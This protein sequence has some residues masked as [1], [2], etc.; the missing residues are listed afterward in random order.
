M[1]QA[2]YRKW[3]PRTFRDVCGQEHITS[4]L[5]YEAE[6]GAF[7]H[8]YLFCGSRGTGKTTCAKILAKVVNCEHP[9]D[10]NPCGVCSACQAID[11]GSATDV[12]EMDAASNNGVENIRDIRDEVIYSPSSLRYRVYIIDEVHMLSASAFNALLKTLE[13]PPQHVVFIL[14]TTELQ[15]LPATIVSRCQRFDFRRIST[16]TLV[17]RLEYIAREEEIDLS[18]DAARMIAKLAQGG[19]RDAISLLELC[20]GGGRTVDVAAVEEAVGISGRDAMIKTVS[21]V[22]EKDYD[23]LFSQIAEVVRSSKD[24]AVFW[25][26]LI[27]LYR[28]ILVMKSTK[29]ARAYLDLTDSECEQLSRLA[30]AFS[31]ETLLLH[32]K[33][34]EDAYFSIKQSTAAKRVIAEMTLVRLC[35]DRLDTSNEALLSRIARLEE[36]VSSGVVQAPASAEKQTAP[37][38]KTQA[39][40]KEAPVKE[41]V[42]IEKSSMPSSPATPNAP[43]LSPVRN[44]MEVVVSVGRVEPSDAGFLKTARAVTDEAGHVIVLFDNAFGVSRIASPAAKERLRVAISTV[45]GRELGEK[46]LI[47]KIAEKVA[48]LSVIDEILESN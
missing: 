11:S 32:C 14:A 9:V 4:I 6:H 7:S 47:L 26:D 38:V 15:K 22:L 40:K 1:Y 10:G 12:L 17:A 33:L 19:M 18:P 5:Q 41:T 27:S 29:S 43:K 39:V 3:R 44:W 21:A 42:K 25:E 45:L 34:L 30:D 20:A 2:F 13:E 37:A 35:D 28:D 23:L 24:I 16:D 31:K 46:D 36:R 48:D 8:A